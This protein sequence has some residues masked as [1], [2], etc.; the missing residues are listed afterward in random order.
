MKEKTNNNKRRKTNIFIVFLIC[1]AL[2]WLISKLSETY[3][4]RSSFD[5]VYVNAPDTLLLTGGSKEYIDARLEASGFRFLSFNFGKQDIKIDLSQIRNT[6]N[7]YFINKEEYQKQIENQ[8]PGNM[9]LLSVDQDTLFLYF[10][11]LFSKEIEIV[12]DITLELAQNHMLEG[13]LKVNPPVV[14]VKGP[15]NEVEGFEKVYT[16]STNLSGITDSFNSSL[17]LAR[18][19][20]MINT[21]Y[22]VDKVEVSGSVF[23]F[24]EQLIDIPVR[25]ENLPE[26]TQ[27]KTFPNAV[28]VLCRAKIDRL[29]S[30]RPQ[31]FE[32]VADFNTVVKGKNE[33]GVQLKSKPAD[34]YDAQLKHNKVE[35]ILIRR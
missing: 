33:I 31:E 15:R 25:V 9:K 11:K 29:K 7:K 10:K 22:S 6:G 5:L 34:V 26:G 3:S 12:P 17:Q 14:T 27:I 2:I 21:T 32:L 28:A 18:N 23:R 16:V 13:K 20:E 24:S 35:F 8:L 4:Q 1:S 30:L 19:P